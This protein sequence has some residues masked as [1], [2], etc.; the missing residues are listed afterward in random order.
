MEKIKIGQELLRFLS[1][2]GHQAYLVGGTVRDFLLGF[3]IE[4]LD[5]AT[6]ATPEQVI[7][8]FP[9]AI[10]TGIK[11]GTVTVKFKEQ[12]IEVT[13]FRSESNYVDY[14]RPTVVTYSE[15][16]EEDLSRRDFTINAL[17]MNIEEGIIDFYDGQTALIERLLKTVGD[18]E[19]RF[20]EDPLRMLRAIR[21]IAQLGF[22]VEKKTWE[23]LKNSAFYVRYVAVERIKKE[24]DRMLGSVYVGDAIIA[25]YASGLL[26]WIPELAQTELPTYDSG[27]LG[28]LIE[29]SDN[30]ITRWYLLLHQLPADDFVYLLDEFCFSK[31]ER[32]E[33]K[34]RSAAYNELEIELSEQS[35][36]SCL[37]AYEKE[38]I[39]EAIKLLY[40]LPRSKN[41]NASKSEPLTYWLEKLDLI[42]QN[43]TVR[44]VTDLQI[45]GRDLI[46]ELNLEAGIIVGDILDELFYR[47]IFQGLPNDKSRLLKEAEKIRGEEIE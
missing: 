11:Y 34:E 20:R 42:D 40:I 39:E 8:L 31:K 43:L 7:D 17:A 27:Y 44:S 21:F 35:L 15:S 45:N 18:A 4:D 41:L 22:Q 3:E 46:A 47:V 36:T 24:F 38:S 12:Y 29:Q 25:L 10:P 5:V 9:D 28:R 1:R 23:Q 30:R 19:E 14:R 37:L 32:Q 26:N 2:H 16:L 6:S 13:T 33:L